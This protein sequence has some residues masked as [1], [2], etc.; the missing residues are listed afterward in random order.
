MVEIDQLPSV[1][2]FPG[3]A[4]RGRCDEIG[5]GIRVNNNGP[6]AVNEVQIQM[7]FPSGLL[8]PVDWNYTVADGQCT[9]DNG[10]G[11][12]DTTF[13]LAIGAAAE[14]DLAGCLDPNAAFV[15]LR[16]RVVS[17]TALR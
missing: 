10:S 6:P 15:D 4:G 16:A 11:A 1:A 8:P 7:P 5:F 13:G 12:I 14:I 3:A 9:P 17:P 2:Q